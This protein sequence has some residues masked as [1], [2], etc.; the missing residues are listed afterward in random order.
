MGSGECVFMKFS[1]ETVWNENVAFFVASF[2]AQ[3]EI[4]AFSLRTEVA[5]LIQFTGGTR[6]K[7]SGYSECHIGNSA[8]VRESVF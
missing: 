8:V 7:R 6:M 5:S 1:R 4:G 3:R 2:Q